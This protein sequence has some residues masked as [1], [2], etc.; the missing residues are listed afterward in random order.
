V[1]RFWRGS[2]RVQTPP[3]TVAERHTVDTVDS[4][5]V[6]RVEQDRLAF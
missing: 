6:N 5:F 3:I 2:I 1:Q 4:D